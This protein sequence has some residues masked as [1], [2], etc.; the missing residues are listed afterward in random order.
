TEWPARV[1]RAILAGDLDAGEGTPSNSEAPIYRKPDNRTTG[2][3]LVMQAARFFSSQLGGLIYADQWDIGVVDAPIHRFLDPTFRPSVRWLGLGDPPHVYAADPFAMPSGDTVL[4]ER[5]DNATRKGEIWQAPLPGSAKPNNEE[6]LTTP[7]ALPLSSHAS[8]P[9]VFSDGSETYCLPQVAGQPPRLYGLH[10]KKWE[11]VATLL[12]E[13]VLDPTVI[14]WG[15]RWWL[16]ATRPGRDSLT[17]L[18]IWWTDHLTGPWRPHTLNPVKTDV[19]SARP[20]GTPF[21][22]DGRL[23]RPA[24]DCSAGYGAAV[25]LCEITELGPTSFTETVVNIVRPD[26]SWPRPLGLHTLSAAGDQT[27]LDAKGRAISRYETAAELRG[28]FQHL[29]RLV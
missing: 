3:F 24:Q 19:R 29:R 17:K 2:R 1:C 22:H 5:F 8:Y 28:R 26:S 7:A 15:G 23:Y 4:Y 18:H 14:R 6:A 27:L 20:A 9:F 12:Q 25:A 13:P 11:E 16:L 21:I 10:D